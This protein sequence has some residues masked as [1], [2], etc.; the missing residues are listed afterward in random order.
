M[1]LMKVILNLYSH[2][3]LLLFIPAQINELKK[4]NLA[5]VMC[6][7]TEG[8]KYM[9]AEVFQVPSS[10]NPLVSCSDSRIGQINLSLWKDK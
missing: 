5:R 7:N 9:Q 1:S 4:A 8:I 10:N 2:F 6:D 3:F